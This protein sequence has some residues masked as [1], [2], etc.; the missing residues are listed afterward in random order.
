VEE[1]YACGNHEVYDIS[2]DGDESYEACGVFHHNSRAVNIQQFPRD[3]DKP[4]HMHVRGCMIPDPG[5]CFIVADYTQLELCALAHILTQLVRY[6]AAHPK[7]KA[8]AEQL[9]K[10]EISETYESSLSRAINANMDCHVLMAS[11]LMTSTYEAIYPIFKQA[12][13]KKDAGQPLDADEK[14]VISQR[15]ISKVCNFGYP[16]GLGAKKFVD[17]AA[18]YNLTVTVD[19]AAT[20]K[21]AYIAAWPEMRLYFDHIGR[22]CSEGD[23]SMEVVQLYSNRIRGGCNFTQ[24]CNALFQSLAADGAKEAL[25]LLIDASYRDLRS[26][27]FGCRPSGFVHDEF[28]INAPLSIFDRMTDDAKPVPVA[29]RETEN[30]MIAGMRKWIPDVVIKAPGKVLRERLSK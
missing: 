20:A 12:D 24:A 4:P 30:L 14:E 21:R 13:A 9:L 19:Q 5:W 28:L 26:P 6:Y 15:Q 22:K 16:G 7:R 3:A 25:A 10:F 27:L 18:G 17:Y 29:L 1:V 23:G 2:V 11:V 8:Y